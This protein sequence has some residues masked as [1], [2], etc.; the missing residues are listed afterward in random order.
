MIPKQKKV[1]LFLKQQQYE[2][3]LTHELAASRLVK[4]VTI[5]ISVLPWFEESFPKTNLLRQFRRLQA[6]H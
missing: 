6:S 1:K 2:P 5:L 3:T 4:G